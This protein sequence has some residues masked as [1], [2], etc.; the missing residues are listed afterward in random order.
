M[1][2]NEPRVGAD[3]T[4]RSSSSTRSAPVAQL[5][6]APDYESGGQRFE[7]FRARH[8]LTRGSCLRC[9]AVPSGGGARPSRRHVSASKSAVLKS[10]EMKS[11]SKWGLFS[12]FREGF[13][14]FADQIVI[15]LIWNYSNSRNC[16]T[17][18]EPRLR[19][20]ARETVRDTRRWPRRRTA[21]KRARAAR[22]GSPPWTRESI[23][24]DR[25]QQ[26]RRDCRSN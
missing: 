26:D 6:R 1:P 12:L 7:S 2:L 25:G 3:R 19:L 20:R 15:P 10:A 22:T 16:V 11:P 14:W 18:C 8:F 13:S 5:D 9:D 4:C 24:R 17:S 21:P 23:L